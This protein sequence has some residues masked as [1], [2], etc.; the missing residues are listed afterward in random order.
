MGSKILVVI[1]VLAAL[2]VGRNYPLYKQCDSRWASEQLGTS[3]NTICKA[4][5]LMSSVAMGLAGIGKSYNP[6]TLNAWLKKNNGYANKDLLVWSSVTSLGLKFE[7]KAAKSKIKSSLDAGKVVILNVHNGQHWV[8][9]TSYSG[10]TIQ[11]NDPGFSVNSY[12]LSQ[13]VENQVGIYSV[14]SR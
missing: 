4:G 1:A 12:T 11:V 14:A 3:T 7:G 6:S 2:V 13:I 8:L 10:D 9:A 5:C